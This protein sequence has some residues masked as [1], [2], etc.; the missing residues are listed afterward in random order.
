MCSSD[1]IAQDIMGDPR[2]ADYH[3]AISAHDYRS[4]W[5]APILSHKGDVLGVFALYSES[6]REPTESEE[7]ILALVPLVAA[8]ALQLR[9]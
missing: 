7:N 1:L 3:A 8:I 2:W 9:S 6:A 4:C 5:S